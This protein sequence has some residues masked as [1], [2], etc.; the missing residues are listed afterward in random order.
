ML[1]HRMKDQAA[2][3][4]QLMIPHLRRRSEQPLAS[5]AFCLAQPQTR[6]VRQTLSL[7]PL[8]IDREDDFANENA[9]HFV[10]HQS[11]GE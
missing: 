8:F 10:P 3:I 11:Q 1:S 7:L 2:G 9:Q 6:R 5:R 4:T